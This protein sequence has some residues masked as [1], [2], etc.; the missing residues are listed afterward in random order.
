MVRRFSLTPDCQAR[1]PLFFGCPK[2]LIQYINSHSKSRGFLPTQTEDAPC[3]GNGLTYHVCGDSLVLISVFELLNC[4]RM[5]VHI[6][7]FSMLIFCLSLNVTVC[8]AVRF[9][10]FVYLAHYIGCIQGV[11][12]MI[13]LLLCVCVLYIAQFMYMEL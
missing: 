2:L 1:G 11:S 12:L 7:W 4:I 3:H 8:D 6:K 13:A 9:E 5:V 10:F